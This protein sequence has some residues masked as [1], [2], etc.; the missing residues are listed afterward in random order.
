M[1]FNFLDY[2]DELSSNLLNPKFP[3][4]IIILSSLGYEKSLRLKLRADGEVKRFI[5]S[6]VYKNGRIR[7]A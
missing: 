5:K 4:L 3:S 7:N 1:V 2:I 6:H